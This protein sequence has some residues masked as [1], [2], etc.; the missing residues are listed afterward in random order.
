MDWFLVLL[1]KKN[2]KS[3][4]KTLQ[5]I[6]KIIFV[7]RLIIFFDCPFYFF[8]L[9]VVFLIESVTQ[10]SPVDAALDAIRTKRVTTTSPPAL[11][12]RQVYY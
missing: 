8:G 9:S 7:L 10:L 4:L 6:F 1:L 3:F 11:R 5:V 12:Q 2:F